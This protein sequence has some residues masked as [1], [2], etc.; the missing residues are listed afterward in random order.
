MRSLMPEFITT[1]M[2]SFKIKLLA[3]VALAA[4]I[5]EAITSA[6]AQAQATGILQHPAV[7]AGLVGALMALL[8]KLI[9]MWWEA[10]KA[11]NTARQRELPTADRVAEL[12]K[13]ERQE[14]REGMAALH[15]REIG[16][17]QMQLTAS[18]MKLAASRIAEAEARV[19]AHTVNREVMRLQRYALKL[20]ALIPPGTPDVPQLEFRDYEELMAAAHEEIERARKEARESGEIHITFN[21]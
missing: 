12:S 18:N 2:A 10:R 8:M 5:S 1:M 21:Q 17:W 7:V 6:P 11:R 3:I 16:F 13:E 20:L 19:A 14:L 9:D 4:G 15:A